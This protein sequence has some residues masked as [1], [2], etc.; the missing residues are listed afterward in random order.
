MPVHL[1]R[2]C[3]W[4][5][6]SPRHGLAIS[7][8]RVI[9]ADGVV[10]GWT[11][12][13]ESP[14]PNITDQ[15]GWL[16]LFMTSFFGSSSGYIFRHEAIANHTFFPTSMVDI[17]LAL[18]IL[19]NRYQVTGFPEASYFYRVHEG[20]SYQKGLQVVRDRNNLRLWLFQRQGLRIALKFPLFLFLVVK[21]AA[22]KAKDALQN[23]GQK[24]A[25]SA[26]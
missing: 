19:L 26:G 10:Q 18:S 23:A 1:E 24:S 14:L 22:S 25:E 15:R 16:R 7:N 17:H 20:S 5:D 3:Q 8:G 12:S 2:A 21:S 11:N 4:L 13:R 6:Q 9:N